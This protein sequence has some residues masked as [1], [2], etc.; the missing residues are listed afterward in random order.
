MYLKMSQLMGQITQP[1]LKDVVM[2]YGKGDLSDILPEKIPSTYAGT[3]FFMTGRYENPGSSALSI[4]GTSSKG[5][6]AYDFMLDFRSETSGYKFIESLWTKQMI[7]YLEWQIEIYGETEELKEKLIEISITYNIRCRY[8]AYVADYETEYTS[9][10]FV[11]HQDRIVPE[12]SHLVQN[13][14]N[15]FN[16]VTTIVFYIS[17]TTAKSGPQLIRIYNVLGQLVYVIDLSP[18][19]PGY[20]EVRFNGSD[21]NGNALPSGVYFVV[22]Q[23]GSEQSMM[24]MTLLR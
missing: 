9:L 11:S 22:M 21:W 6:Q 2:E 7:E 19:G 4:A 13:Y 12:H 18:Y 14:P 16:P 23:A 10:I 3:Y 8:T 20:H 5:P 1:I 17:P 24:R 15:P